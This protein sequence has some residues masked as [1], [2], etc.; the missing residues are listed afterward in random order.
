MTKLSHA[1]A[2]ILKN[3]PYKDELSNARVTKMIYLADWHSLINGKPALSDIKW[4]FD[5]YGPFVWDVKNA[6]A[7]S[8]FLKSKSTHNM[9]GQPKELIS[10]RDQDFEPKID[11]L[12]AATLDHVIKQTKSL[13]WAGFIKL[14]YST[15]PVASSEK[16][17]YLDLPKLAKKYIAS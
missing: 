2:Y 6:V 8:N 7:E 16:Y 11:T 9:F 5:N 1:I 3:Y 15:Y 12:D 4:Y 14:V 13:N 17:S 10:L